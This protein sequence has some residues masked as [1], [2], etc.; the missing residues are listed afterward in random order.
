MSKRQYQPPKSIGPNLPAP[1][2]LPL[3]RPI[4]IYYRQ[5][6]E[7]QVGNVST[8]LQTVDMVA[9]LQRQGWDDGKI[10]MIDMDA[11]ISGTTKIDERP[12][13]SRLFRLITEEKIGAVACQDEDRLFRDV[14]QI[15]VNIFIEACR[16]HQVLILTPSMTYNFG[17]EQLGTF[18]AR[19]F[20]FKSE[21]AAEYINSVV[22]GKLHAARRSLQM[23]GKW[24]GGAVPAGY[25]VDIRKT[26]PDGQP[27]GQWRRYAVF[28]P[29][30]AVVREYFRLYLSYAGNVQKTL[31]HIQRHGPHYPNPRECLPPEGFRTGYHLQQN[32][33]GWCPKSPTSLTH[34]FTNATYI[35]HWVVNATVVR[36]HNHPALIEDTVFF[37]AFNS[38]ARI[39]LDGALNPHYRERTLHTRPSKDETRPVERPLYAGLLYSHGD[40][41]LKQVGTNWK[42][43]KGCY[44]YTFSVYDGVVR[45]VW[46]KRSDYLD[47]TVCRL[48]LD[49][50]QC[51]FDLAT[52][53]AA[54]EELLREMHEQQKLIAAQLQQL[55]RVMENLIASL[56]SVTT[57]QLITVIEAKYQD[58]LAEQERLQREL[59]TIGARVAD[60]RTIGTVKQAFA[61]ALQHWEEMTADAKREVIHYVID[62]LVA[63]R[64]DD[65]CLDLLI[66]WRD[67]SQ[68]RLTLPRAPSGGTVWLPQETARLCELVES[69]AT[70]LEI[71]RAFPDRAWKYIYYKYH[72]HTKQPL[73]L[74]GNHPLGRYETYNQYVARTGRLSTT[75]EVDSRQARPR[76][77]ARSATRSA[78]WSA[79]SQPRS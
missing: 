23:S 53:E 14:T 68:D 9:Y 74:R 21:M 8:T 20:R 48:L 77:P 22:R 6:T 17:H 13:M 32:A 51:T 43:A 24:A 46:N 1:D 42:A 26:L 11:G 57:P 56:A 47:D 37:Q 52:W 54:G 71:A 39:A 40:G 78:A 44:H 69:G 60:V 18:H 45:P 75:S 36:W 73:D 33:Y 50:L 4:A 3:A 79:H 38:I 5:S 41:C 67:E 15:Q 28:E 7:A 65:G 16:A 63:T 2:R 19:Q 35:G 34:M 70:Q 59:G 31:R 76:S 62:K 30:A 61:D 49:K 29:Y 64:T 27:N 72:S 66:Y 55:E 58:A 12:G 25:M 10:I